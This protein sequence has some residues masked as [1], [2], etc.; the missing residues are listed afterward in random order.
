MKF[1]RPTL[2]LVSLVLVAT[3]GD[4][5]APPVA[6]KVGFTTQPAGATAGTAIAPSIVIAAQDANGATITTASGINVTL[7]ITTGTGV[8]GATLGGTLTRAAIA[9]VATFDDITIDKAGSGYTLTATAAGLTIATTSAFAVSPGAAA[10]L[11]VASQPSAANAGASIAP[12]VQFAIQDALGNTVTSATSNITVAISSGTGA[13]G[14]VL[15]GTTT[16]AAVSGV[17]TFSNLSLD[18]A[19]SGYTFTGSA[20]GLTSATTAAFTISPAAAAKL[21]VTVQPASSTA[22]VAISPS[23]QVS[24]QDALGN[25]VPSATTSITVAVTTG[26]GAAGATLGGTKTVSASSGIAAFS[27]LSL[28][29]AASGYTLTATASGMTS[30]TSSAFT[31]SPAAAAKLA[32]TTQPSNSTGGSAISPNVVVTIQDT[33]GNTASSATTSVTMAI[34]SGTG[35]GGATLG[36]TKTVAAV[37]GV[38]T[39]STLAVDKTGTG[40]TLDATA[41]GLTGATT[42]AFNVALGSPAKLFFAFHPSNAV[43]MVVINPSVQVSVHDAGNNF[44]S[45]ATN[46]VTIAIGT[47]PSGASSTL[48]GTKTVAAVAGVATFNDLKVSL[49]ATGYTLVA[50]GTGLSSA[51]SETFNISVGPVSQLV[52]VPATHGQSAQVGT[53]VAL[54]PAVTV[55]DAGGNKIADVSISWVIKEGGGSVTGSPSISN[56]NGVATVGSWTLGSAV[57]HNELTASVTTNAAIKTDFAAE[58]TGGTPV[59][60]TY[61]RGNG[62]TS[63]VNGYP[64]PAPAV[65]VKDA[66]GNPAPGA[67]I[68]WHITTGGISL[69]DSVSTSLNN[70]IA[71]V[72]NWARDTVPGT[73][74][75]TASSATL[76]GSPITFTITNIA[77]SANTI[78]VAAGDNQTATVSTAVAIAPSVKVTD[79]YGNPRS[80]I[81]VEF[82]PANGNSGS[83]TG[84]S[85]TV[86]TNASG[87]ATLTGPWTLG[88]LPGT[89]KL[90]ADFVD[91]NGNHHFLEFS[92]TAIP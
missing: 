31:I 74:V 66:N 62:V 57:A 58:G 50:S 48:L 60:M 82:Q 32:V 53:A 20:T 43:S 26:T 34:T 87:I 23:V 7:S 33:F 65:I 81:S 88:G 8:T 75:V 21:A 17:A 47:D 78:T 85:V 45:S 6:V 24:V 15:S 86:L 12:A 77:D 41:T 29:K 80:G 44:L 89:H 69:A 22:G 79:L 16:A 68:K 67:V 84:G 25:T 4:S 39:F 2:G 91:H 10:K 73:N 1:I 3:C 70:G 42:S 71:E 56:A 49:K 64:D 37:A 52:K 76:T 72:P 19:A 18:K 59:S 14:A 51:T 5:T 63:S 30:A 92:A 55:T 13:G 35:T 28:D 83:V 40:Y 38:A 9:G 54:A 61:L 36:G 11:G 46:S 90:R 27:T